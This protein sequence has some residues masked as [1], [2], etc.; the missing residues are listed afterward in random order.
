MRSGFLFASGLIVGIM[1]CYLVTKSSSIRHS[2]SEPVKAALAPPP[3][4]PAENAVG[5]AAIVVEKR[6]LPEI[7]PT[8][9]AAI[10]VRGPASVPM[11]ANARAIAQPKP[12]LTHV[13]LTEETVTEMELQWNDLPLQAEV[14]R[15]RRGWRMLKITPGSLLASTGL[16]EGDLVTKESLNILTGQTDQDLA[17][18]VAEILNHMTSH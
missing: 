2:A 14:S 15:D 12:S 16:R 5:S 9:S 8:T 7:L 4:E 6:Q 13:T 17:N 18:R 10:R 3:L 11:D 1:I